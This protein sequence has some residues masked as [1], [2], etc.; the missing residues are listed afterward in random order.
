MTST[1]VSTTLGPLAVRV[2]GTGRPALLWHSLYADSTTW[3][4]LEQTLTAHRT[5]V[6]ID[7]PAHGESPAGTRTPSLQGCAA[8]AGEV[9]DALGITGPVDWVGKAWG[10][11]VGIVFATS[12][13]ERCRSLCVV[14]TPVAALTGRERAETRLLMG[15][16][17]MLGP[18]PLAGLLARVL[19]GKNVDVADPDARSVFTKAY[20]RTSRRGL[21]NVVGGISLGRP[22]LT[23]MLGSVGVPTLVVCAAEDSMLSTHSARAATRGLPR[24][25]LVVLPTAGHIGPLL[26]TPEQLGELVTRFWADPADTVASL[27][28]SG[29]E[30]G[31]VPSRLDVQRPASARTWGVVAAYTGALAGAALALYYVLADPLGARDEAWLWLGPANDVL[32]IAFY[33]ALSSAAILTWKE[34]RGTVLA[35]LAALLVLSSATSTVS[36]LRLLTGVGG[37]REQSLASV[38]LVALLVTWLV[39]AARTR[40]GAARPQPS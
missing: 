7:G 20:A 2:I 34:R 1:L 15:L 35:A 5:L 18:D 37:L 38:P 16:Y 40:P 33:G 31:T 25:G 29:S 17:R 8:A 3:G 9:L 21:A 30:P 11:H 12:H 14:G 28:V 27:R 32:S 26:R 4:R 24:G 13:P 22:D 10:G 19:L 23:P 36:T 39:A 6:M